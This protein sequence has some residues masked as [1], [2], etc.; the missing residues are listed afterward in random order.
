MYFAPICWGGWSQPEGLL[1]Q[2]KGNNPEDADK[3][4]AQHI[5]SQQFAHG[6]FGIVA[7]AVV[8]FLLVRFLISY[9]VRAV[10]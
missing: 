4:R 5:A 2:N 7:G 6:F 8:L 3:R 10:L 1:M 9:L